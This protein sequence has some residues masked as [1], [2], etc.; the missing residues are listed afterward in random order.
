MVRTKY[1]FSFVYLTTISLDCISFH[2]IQVPTTAHITFYTYK[3]TFHIIS[4][5]KSSLFPS[6]CSAC[7][8]LLFF[9]L[10]WKMKNNN[11]WHG[12]W[13]FVSCYRD[14][15]ESERGLFVLRRKLT[16]AINI[17][18]NFSFIVFV[19]M[20]LFFMVLSTYHALIQ[21]PRYISRGALC[22]N[23]LDTFNSANLFECFEALH[24][25]ALKS[26]L[27]YLI[28]FFLIHFGHSKW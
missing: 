21:L 16:I 11:I 22:I 9:H 6:E 12:E 1:K 2:F 4:S 28:N 15:V 18:N 24:G 3:T 8:V 23:R 27:I 10:K 13:K 17:F 20:A 14:Y 5:V 25:R 7:D 26:V 19:S